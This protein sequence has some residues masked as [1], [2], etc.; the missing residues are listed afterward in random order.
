MRKKSSHS[1]YVIFDVD[2]KCFE[3][4]KFETRSDLL[5]VGTDKSRN[6]G[7]E[8]GE[9]SPTQALLWW[10]G[11]SCHVLFSCGGKAQITMPFPI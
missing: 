10:S 11:H 3:G 7:E 9:V 4:Y 2:G 5:G 6:C 8:G 1:L